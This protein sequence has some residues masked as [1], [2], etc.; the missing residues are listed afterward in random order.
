MKTDLDPVFTPETLPYWEGAQRGELRL[1]VCA[2][3]DR[4][5]FP[6]SNVCPRCSS[7][8]E[9]EWRAASGRGTLY[10]FVINPRPDARW[11]IEGPMSVAMVRLE[12]GPMMLSTVVNCP[13]TVEA[14]RF[15]MDLRAVFRPYGDLP[16]VVCFE[17][18]VGDDA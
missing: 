13:Q 9:V 6:P 3:C 11:G 5:F 16:S 2:A 8:K 7:S 18:V 17:P 15:D 4:F 12:E 14:L 1:C 10:S